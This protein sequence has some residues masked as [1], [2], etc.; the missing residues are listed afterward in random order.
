[1]SEENISIPRS[2]FNEL[3]KL[4]GELRQILS[5]EKNQ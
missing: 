1:M 5:G 2:K 3:Q 4:I